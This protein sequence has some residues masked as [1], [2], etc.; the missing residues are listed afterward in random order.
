[1][2]RL[3]STCLHIPASTQPPRLTTNTTDQDYGTVTGDGI[4]KG[5]FGIPKLP[6]NRLQIY[7]DRR[8]DI[9]LHWRILH[10]PLCQSPTTA[11]RI[12]VC[13]PQDRSM[14][15]PISSEVIDARIKD[16]V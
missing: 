13:K 8:A 5:A 10:E 4:E 16:P 3:A 2:V 12:Q 11:S 14:A 15:K 7:K 9:F 1:M 6:T